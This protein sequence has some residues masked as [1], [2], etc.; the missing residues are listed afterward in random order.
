VRQK[1]RQDTQSGEFGHTRRKKTF[2][3]GL[4]ARKLNSINQLH[5]MTEAGQMDRC[6]CAS[7]ARANNQ[8]LGHVS[9]V[10][11]PSASPA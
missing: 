10:A 11:S 2:A 5:G 1:A 3:A 7:D 8:D 4:A 9:I 6:G